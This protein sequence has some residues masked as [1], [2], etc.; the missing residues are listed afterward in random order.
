MAKYPM[1]SMFV[2]YDA[3]ANRLRLD[4]YFKDSDGHRVHFGENPDRTDVS[5]TL[6]AMA[7]EIDR[8]TERAEGIE[9]R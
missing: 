9:I 1:I 4:V 5:A 7:E 6:R 2:G 8:G 3:N